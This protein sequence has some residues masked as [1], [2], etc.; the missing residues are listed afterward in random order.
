MTMLER[1]YERVSQQMERCR[2]AI[3]LRP[4][5]SVSEKCLHGR[6]Y[7][8]LARRERQRV[9]FTYIGPADSARARRI[10]ASVAERRSFQALLR[11]ARKSRDE[12][13]RAIGR[14]SPKIPDLA[15]IDPIRLLDRN[16]RHARLARHLRRI[17]EAA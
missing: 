1:E 4:A 16:F 8:Y 9:T 12:L 3:D 7:A 2:R 14:L 5:G 15:G 17:N 11:V 10:A 13:R 6:R